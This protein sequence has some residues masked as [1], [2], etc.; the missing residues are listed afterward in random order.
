[1]L[2]SGGGGSRAGSPGEEARGRARAEFYTNTLVFFFFQG[3]ISKT[4][5]ATVRIVI[6]RKT[7]STAFEEE[8]AFRIPIIHPASPG[9]LSSLGHSLTSCQHSGPAS[10]ALYTRA[11]TS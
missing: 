5:A 4:E 6:L 7:P 8:L 3:L 9:G 11:H 10:P 1:M 2:G